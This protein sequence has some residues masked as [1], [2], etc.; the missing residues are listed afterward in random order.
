MPIKKHF[1]SE[2]QKLLMAAN[3]DNGDCIKLKEM[4]VNVSYNLTKN[5][6]EEKKTSA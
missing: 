4:L 6:F 2:Y 5:K 3:M 1:R